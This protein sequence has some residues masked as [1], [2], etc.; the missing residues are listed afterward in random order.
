MRMGVPSD[1][2]NM[3]KDMKRLSCRVLLL[4]S[5]LLP[6]AGQSRE[7][8]RHFVN[9]RGLFH[10]HDDSGDALREAGAEFREALRLA[11]KYAS[12]EAYLGLIA[13]EEEHFA[14]AETA[15][16]RALSWDPR[17]AEA[18]VGLAQLSQRGGRRD[19][20]LGL[21]RKAVTGVPQNVLARHALADAL[22][23]EPVQPTAAMWQEA[24]ASLRV[25]I[26]I[27]RNDRDAQHQLARGYRQL[28]RWNEAERAFR[29]VLRIGQTREDSDV[30]VYSVHAELGE[31]LARQGKTGEAIK[32]YEALIASVGA[33]EEEIRNARAAIAAL[34]VT[35]PVCRQTPCPR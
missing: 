28:G 5:F 33:G 21:L 3:L 19:E 30:W 16:R 22:T 25:L 7:A 20:A 12:A 18:L 14:E 32:E 23:N 27:D 17:C 10:E 24:I 9:G 2:P 31:A 29:E 34:R 26:A 4:A 15:Y 13:A 11:P 8:Q 35:T 1:R 6:L